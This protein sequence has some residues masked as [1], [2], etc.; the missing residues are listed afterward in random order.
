MF[1]LVA[2]AGTL[3]S[4]MLRPGFVVCLAFF[5]MGVSGA[6]G[7]VGVYMKSCELERIGSREANVPV[8]S[9]R[10]SRDCCRVDSSCEQFLFLVRVVRSSRAR[11]CKSARR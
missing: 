5:G 10:L 1:T 6:W 2:P 3:W 8:P 9:W 4:E 7:E 11:W